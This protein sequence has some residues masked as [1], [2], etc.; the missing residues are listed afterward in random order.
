ME[1][2]NSDAGNARLGGRKGRARAGK[3]SQGGQRKR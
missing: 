1:S 2:D 3:G